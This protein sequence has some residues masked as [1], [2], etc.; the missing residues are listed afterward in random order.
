MTSVCLNSGNYHICD[1]QTC[2]WRTATGDD[3]YETCTLTGLQREEVSYA[4][5]NV[6]SRDGETEQMSFTNVS[7]KKKRVKGVSSGDGSKTRHNPTELFETLALGIVRQLLPDFKDKQTEEVVDLCK[8][9][10]FEVYKDALATAAI[11]SNN[12]KAKAKKKQQRSDGISNNN[13]GYVPASAHMTSFCLV[14]LE[15][16]STTGFFI[17]TGPERTIFIWNRSALVADQFPG[18]HALSD[19]G[20]KWKPDASKETN[21]ALSQLGVQRLVK[22]ASIISG[23][24]YSIFSDQIGN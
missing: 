22:L 5:F 21:T 15:K 6:Y 1:P 13:N 18:T 20:Y 10:Y 9:V 19:F 8:T 2:L 7:R 3:R 17:R 4:K 12:S 16:I 24:Q 23:K 11:A 14:M